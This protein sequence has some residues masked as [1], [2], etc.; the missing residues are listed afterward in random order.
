MKLKKK[1]L[2]LF[3]SLDKKILLFI[4]GGTLFLSF[5]I[6]LLLVIRDSM[7]DKRIEQEESVKMAYDSNRLVSLT[8]DANKRPLIFPEMIE[9]L[10]L[11]ADPLRPRDFEW[12]DDE[13]NRLWIEPDPEDIDYFSQANH[14]LIWSLLQNAP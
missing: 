14:A 3:A 8:E 4:A 6:I 13:V 12:T 1:I 2:K 5:S 7:A 9:E 10:E 11:S